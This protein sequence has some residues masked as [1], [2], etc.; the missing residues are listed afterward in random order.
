VRETSV[1]GDVAVE[2]VQARQRSSPLRLAVQD[3]APAFVLV[4]NKALGDSD[5]A[6]RASGAI[7]GHGRLGNQ[8][9]GSWLL[10]ARRWL[11]LASLT[12]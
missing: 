10:S 12:A 4:P 2:V 8:F 7:A 9:A 6:L 3:Q 1:L 5:P 11:C